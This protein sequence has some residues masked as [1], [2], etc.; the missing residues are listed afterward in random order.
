MT[1]AI[2]K[3]N[4]NSMISMYGA[5]THIQIPAFRSICEDGHMCRALNQVQEFLHR[6]KMGWSRNKQH[7]T[8][9]LS[10]DQ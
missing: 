8:K 3:V 5:Y 4:G 2:E 9:I 6:S 1:T 7:I 10:M